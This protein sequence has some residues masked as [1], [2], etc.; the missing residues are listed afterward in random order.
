MDER[1]EAS[2]MVKSR[3]VMTAMPAYVVTE[4]AVTNATEALPGSPMKWKAGSRMWDMVSTT[5]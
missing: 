3:L 5:P 4:A 1:I 2:R